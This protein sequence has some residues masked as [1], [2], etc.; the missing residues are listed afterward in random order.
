MPSVGLVQTMHHCWK[1]KDVRPG[2]RPRIYVTVKGKKNRK[3]T[4]VSAYRVCDNFVA[5]AG[6]TTCWKQ[7]W[8]YLRK[9]GYVEP[10]PRK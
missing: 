7:Q 3:V 4:I 9:K 8:R 6:P 10:D 2:N 1:W 5:Q